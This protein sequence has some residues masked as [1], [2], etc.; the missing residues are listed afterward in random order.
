MI[1]AMTVVM[2]AALEEKKGYDIIQYFICLAFLLL[3]LSTIWQFT[4]FYFL[5]LS[6]FILNLL[7]ISDYHDDLCH[8]EMLELE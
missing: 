8:P 6:S 5:L 4:H 3:E 7:Y 1:D 2:N